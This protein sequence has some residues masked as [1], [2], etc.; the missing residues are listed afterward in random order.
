MVQSCA[1][2]KGLNPS[3]GQ[4]KT[5]RRIVDAASGCYTREE[6]VCESRIIER[7]R[8][9]FGKERVPVRTCERKQ[10]RYCPGDKGYEK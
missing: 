7:K 2:L 8:L 10:V 1:A 3:D 5:V 9:L 6:D 4:K